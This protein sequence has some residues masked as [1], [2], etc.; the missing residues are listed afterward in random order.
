[1]AKWGL[2]APVTAIAIVA[3]LG[4]AVHAAENRDSDVAR[5]KALADAKEIIAQADRIELQHDCEPTPKQTA[6]ITDPAEI[7]NTLGTIRYVSK[8]PCECLHRDFAVFSAGD[9]SVKVS[10]CDH[11]FDVNTGRH[12]FLFKMPPEFYD[13]F[14]AKFDIP[15]E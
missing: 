12:L 7:A 8:D 14:R 6:V 11:C 1:M 3:V 13:A 5:A 4:F 9:R 2:T 15:K 10:L